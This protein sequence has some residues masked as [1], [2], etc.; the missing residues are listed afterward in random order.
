[1]GGGDRGVGLAQHGD[2]FCGPVLLGG[3][4]FEDTFGVADQVRCASLDTGELGVELVPAGV[5]VAD[6]VA[7]VA[8]QYA[9][10]GE[11]GFGSGADR[12]IPDQPR[13]GCAP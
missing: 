12:G 10:S 7:G 2:D 11:G 8:L 9:Q 5:V 6:Q 1:V 3:I 13:I 4:Q